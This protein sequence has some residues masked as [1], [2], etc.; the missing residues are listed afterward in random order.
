V[1][2]ASYGSLGLFV[3]IA[4]GACVAPPERVFRLALQSE[5]SPRDLAGRTAEAHPGAV[6]WARASE[7]AAAILWASARSGDAAERSRALGAVASAGVGAEPVLRA[8]ARDDARLEVRAFALEALAR[9]GHRGARRILARLVGSADH[10]VRAHALFTL[11]LRSDA[12]VLREALT[13]AHLDLRLAALRR[14]TSPRGEAIRAIL[15]DRLARD[16]AEAVRALAARRLASYGA[17]AEDA[18]AAALDDPSASVSAAAAEALIEAI[19]ARAAGRLR[20]RLGAGDPLASLELARAVIAGSTRAGLDDLA[21]PALAYVVA[22][23][24][25]TDLRIKAQAIAAIRSIPRRAELLPPLRRSREA[26]AEPRLRL[27]VILAERA[28]G[29]SASTYEPALR[30]LTSVAGMVGLQAAAERLAMGDASAEAHLTAAAGAGD[31][32][33]RAVAAEA[34][35]RHG[36]EVGLALFAVDDPDLRVRLRWAAAVLSARVRDGRH[37]R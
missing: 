4:M 8:L 1:Q 28:H 30:A 25:S 3:V 20:P 31:P 15:V 9:R 12:D 24:D 13:S 33:L 7:A 32:L 34:L 2:C 18:L 27:L 23:L 17:A 11:D 36:R 26:T 16:P 29:A 35:A 14:I 5:A 22:H 37:L 21:A 6:G 10:E 19:G